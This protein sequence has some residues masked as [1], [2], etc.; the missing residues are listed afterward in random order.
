V[1]E[2]AKAFPQGVDKLTA[3][4]DML[5]GWQH[6]IADCLEY[7]DEDLA[8]LNTTRN[9]WEKHHNEDYLQVA[10]DLYQASG[11]LMEL[12]EDEQDKAVERFVQE[13]LLPLFKV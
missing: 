5:A 1:R 2:T 12:P 7:T 11:E 3:L 9:E 13:R 6:K 8:E 10:F 4:M